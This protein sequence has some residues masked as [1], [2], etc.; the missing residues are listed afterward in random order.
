MA[1][2]ATAWYPSRLLCQVISTI[3]GMCYDNIASHGRGVPFPQQV[4]YSIA[5]NAMLIHHKRKTFTRARCFFLYF[6]HPK[7]VC[8]RYAP[9]LRTNPNTIRKLKKHKTYFTRFGALNNFEVK[10]IK[11]LPCAHELHVYVRS[12]A[13]AA[14]PW[15][16]RGAHSFPVITSS[17]RQT[18]IVLTQIAKQMWIKPKRE[19]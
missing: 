2:V 11:T 6:T 3:T 18:L 9:A 8:D 17:Y 14:Q 4:L 10:S 15:H 16:I 5:A 7:T 12:T 1:A 19:A 13:T